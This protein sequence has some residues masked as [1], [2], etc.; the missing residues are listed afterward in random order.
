M[1]TA[2]PSL[3]PEQQA[4]QEMHVEPYAAFNDYR[5]YLHVSMG[6]SR[7]VVGDTVNFNAHIKCNP[8]ERKQLVEQLTYAVSLSLGMF[9]D[10]KK[11]NLN[12]NYDCF[13]RC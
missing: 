13:C 3:K 2:D 1:E 7:V 10:V 8:P 6:S 9:W 4:I 12:R 11:L 5:N